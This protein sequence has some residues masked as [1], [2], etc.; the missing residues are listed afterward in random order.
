MR[1]PSPVLRHVDSGTELSD[2]SRLAN[3]RAFQLFQISSECSNRPGSRCEVWWCCIAGGRQTC[4]PRLSADLY[5]SDNDAARLTRMK[6]LVVMSGLP[7]TGKSTVSL[8]LASELG[9]LALSKDVIEAALWRRGVGRELQSSW[10]AHEILTAL[11]EDSLRQGRGVVVD[12]V[13]TTEEVRQDWR[14]AAQSHA[15]P[16]VVI[17]CECSDL[18]T[19]RRR[20][21]GRTRGIAGWPELQWSDVE[22]SR[23][24]WEEWSEVHLTLD[25]MDDK[26][27]N[28]ARALDYVRARIHETELSG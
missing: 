17:V 27:V 8:A 5:Q 11:V 7:G 1:S 24:R 25:S 2:R 15:V 23:G 18:D 12:T 20:L 6:G 16:F 28:V 21:E 3:C 9:V 26:D 13:A 10:V 19:H 14:N 22:S 4:R